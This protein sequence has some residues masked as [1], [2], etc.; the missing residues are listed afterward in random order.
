MLTGGKEGA[1]TANSVRLT[2]TFKVAK[3]I[4][5]SSDAATTFTE[6]KTELN[7]QLGT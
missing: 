3:A 7:A 6:L 1:P 5:A 4:A 2:F